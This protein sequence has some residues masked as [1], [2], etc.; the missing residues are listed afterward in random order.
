MKRLLIG[1]LL[2]IWPFSAYAQ[3]KLGPSPVDEVGVYFQSEGKW[4]DLPP[5]V[6][7]WKTGGVL[8]H[9]GTLGAL[10]RET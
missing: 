6:V 3:D 2:L 5:E 9:V 1:A 8:K 10:S 7:N 4:A